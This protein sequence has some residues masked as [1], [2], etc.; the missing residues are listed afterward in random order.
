MASEIWVCAAC[1]SV[2]GL[3]AKSCYRCRTPK[4]RGGVDASTI[5]MAQPGKLRDI[6]LP[7]YHSPRLVAVLATLVILAAAAVQIVSTTIAVRIYLYVVEHPALLNVVPPPSPPF[8]DLNTGLAITIAQLGLALLGLTCWALWLSLAVR[9]M[10]ALGL[11]YP[12]ASGTS[13]FLENFYPIVNVFRVPA[14]VRDLVRRLHPELGRGD[15]LIVLALLGLLGS[16]FLP[17]IGIFVSRFNANSAVEK[18]RNVIVLQVIAVVPLIF[19][20]FFLVVLMWWLDLE[21]GRRRHLQ[22]HGRQAPPAP[23]LPEAERPIRDD[24][25]ATAEPLVLPSRATPAPIPAAPRPTTQPLVG[26]PPIRA[27]GITDAGTTL[28]SDDQPRSR[29]AP[30]RTGRIRVEADAAVRLATA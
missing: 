7:D 9:T 1:R 19:G 29:L 30:S 8:L 24:A 21:I 14:I 28:P 17:R 5:D 23:I 12:A 4:D 15:A 22:L 13:A 25:T 3:R 27:L 6:A 10:P 26:M 20:V 2:N 18:Y 11:G 16:L